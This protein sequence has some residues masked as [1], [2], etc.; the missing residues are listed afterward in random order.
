MCR[1]AV[2]RAVVVV[3]LASG[4]NS[5]ISSM[6]SVQAMAAL[7]DPI[8]V[9][10]PRGVRAEPRAAT[11]V[12][13]TSSGALVMDREA[14]PTGA[15][16]GPRQRLVVGPDGS[17]DLRDRDVAQVLG[18]RLVAPVP[19]GATA[20]SS[21]VL[22]E[23][24]W[25]DTV[26]PA[27]YV[28]IATTEDGV[29]VRSG[30]AQDMELAILPWAGGEPQPVAGLPAGYSIF[31]GVVATDEASVLLRGR[32]DS[33]G[34]GI[35][36]VDTAARE[37]WPLPVDPSR[38]FLNDGVLAWHAPTPDWDVEIRTM[39]RPVPGSREL[40]AFQ[41]RPTA[42]MPVGQQYEDV[43]L[44]PV[45]ED[46]VVSRRRYS[47]G[48]LRR[49][50]HAS[51]VRV[52]RADGTVADLATWGQDVVPTRPG[53][54]ALVGDDGAS[55]HGIQ[56]LDVS[57]GWRTSLLA[58]SPVPA[59]TGQVAVDGDR[60]VTVDTSAARNAV[61]SRNVNFETA[62]TSEPQLLGSGSPLYPC[63]Y[64]LSPCHGVLAEADF[65]GWR[66]GTGSSADVWH[67]RE[68]DGTVLSN[69]PGWGLSTTAAL[70]GHHVLVEDGQVLDS[71]TGTITPVGE[72]VYGD[73]HDGAVY[74]PGAIA[75]VPDDAVVA[76]DVQTRRAELIPVPGCSVVHDVRA[77]GSWILAQCRFPDNSLDWVVLDR[78][79]G[80]A[81]W[82]LGAGGS[83]VHLGN[84]FVVRRTTENHLEWT[85]LDA[86]TPQWRALG[87]VDSRVGAYRGGIAASRGATPTVAWIASGS[88]KAALLPVTTSP[89]PARPMAVPL[90]SQPTVRT[91]AWDR[92]VELTWDAP[93]PSEQVTRHL[94][95]PYWS[96]G[97][98]AVDETARK[99]II[100]D[101]TN[102]STYSFTVDAANIAGRTRTT[103]NATPL[104]PP[105][106]PQL[107]SA[108]ADSATSE[109]TVRW[110]WA[111]APKSEAI[112]AFEVT[113]YGVTLGRFPAADRQGTVAVADARPDA[114]I[115]VRAIG[116]VQWSESNE[117]L[118]DLPGVDSIA[119]RVVQRPVA[120]VSVGRSVTVTTAASDDRLLAGVDVR[121]RSAAFGSAPGAWEYPTGW[122]GRSPGTLT[123]ANLAPGRMYCF[124][125]RARDRAGNTSP[126]T[127]PQCT[128][129]PLDDRDLK[130]GGKWQPL[131]GRGYYQGT[132]LR[133]ASRTA[134]LARTRV[135]AEAV[136]LVVSTCPNCGAVAIYEGARRVATVNL[137]ARSR[138][139]QVIQVT[140]PGRTHSA[141]TLRPA[142]T[143]PVIVDGIALRSW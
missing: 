40:F 35:L 19:E 13:R 79:Y 52:V 136:W 33:T 51:P 36:F 121:R 141:L 50:L 76:R 91:R 29:V 94:V 48:Q 111:A 27:G 99:A 139:R 95:G 115:T 44:L 61:Q 98:D 26:V 21:R 63:Q 6:G 2:A 84:G 97:P 14:D 70:S 66:E 77:A 38:A 58:F 15:S 57:S 49:T 83:E 85:A 10:I 23:T 127:T 45:G 93:D 140:W 135:R 7:A 134:S 18:D 133:S 11:L 3:L 96:L 59:L 90:P 123:M 116:D 78:T 25:A 100:R 103:V 60:V 104:A 124:A 56:E 118:V 16:T 41:S 62:T 105:A 82:R 67:L 80:T 138:H 39:R 126:W 74:Q 12:G 142:R 87:T 143:G 108:T 102:G 71:R 75:H 17:E 4:L 47:F 73:L 32:S 88:V 130:R 5:A 68:P 89:R 81:P 31:D 114:R 30:T 22:P 117:I 132:A 125:S 112:R 24:T 8:V 55:G 65:V 1:R 119:P 43:D 101:L 53:Y 110:S 54:I 137:R 113:D 46:V 69:R 34:K 64:S 20:V 122:Q 129:V 109:L 106:R 9:D 86:G 107:L 37:A 92:T 28:A 72:Y 128:S 120:P 42:T 131:S